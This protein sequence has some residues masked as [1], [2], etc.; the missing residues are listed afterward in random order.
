[1]QIAI[2]KLRPIDWEIIS[3]DFHFVVFQE[4]REPYFDRIDYALLLTDS[5]KDHAIGFVTVR[6]LDSF[7]AYL[8]HGG[9]IP[10][11]QNSI[12]PYKCFMEVL[13]LLSGKYKRM[14]TLVRNDNFRMLKLYISIGAKIIGIRTF[15]NEIYLEHLIE[16]NGG[17][18][19]NI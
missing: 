19:G 4:K 9:I 10:Q 3:K 18:D 14:S 1:M 13:K 17:N 15:D 7:T 11:Y 6:E 2:Q 12:I 5:V 8:Q 16:F